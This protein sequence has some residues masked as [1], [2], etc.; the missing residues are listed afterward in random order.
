MLM[1]SWGSGS[2]S[3]SSVLTVGELENSSGRAAVLDSTFWLRL[4][5]TAL[6][7]RAIDAKRALTL[8]PTQ[9]AD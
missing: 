3:P 8:V 9:D 4:G 7:L 5:V 6:D 2:T 1:P